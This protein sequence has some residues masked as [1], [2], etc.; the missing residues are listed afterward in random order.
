M[1]VASITLTTSSERQ[2][3]L[4]VSHASKHL[5][6]GK[7]FDRYFLPYGIN[8]AA[9]DLWLFSPFWVQN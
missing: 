5:M 3:Y 8:C 2:R 4:A 6:S 9:K 1:E 7:C